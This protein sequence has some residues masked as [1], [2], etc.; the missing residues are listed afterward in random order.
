MFVLKR[1]AL[2]AIIFSLPACGT[3]RQEL[4]F[5]HLNDTY[6]IGPVEE[7][8]AGG[9]GRVSTIIQRLQAEGHDV[10]I[11][12]GGDFLYPS[13]ESQIWDGAQMIDA[14]NYLDRVA[15][16][17]VVAGNHEFD[18]RTPQALIDAVTASTF[19]WIGG[20][21]TFNTGDPSVDQT[22]QQEMVIGLQDGVKLGF[23]GLTL[24]ADDGGNARDYVPIDPDYLA[25]AR[26][27]LARLR[28]QGVDAII[29]V[30]HVHIHT[31][32]AVAALKADYPEL[33]FIVGGHEHEPEHVPGTASTAPVMK[34]ASN[35][36][37]IWVIRL[38]VSDAGPVVVGELVDV[39]ASVPTDPD[40]VKLRDGWRTQ[41]LERFPFLEARIG[42]AAAPLDAREVTVRN[43]ESGWGNFIADQMRV[44][45]GRTPADLAFVNGG[46][47]RLDDYIAGDITFEDVARTFGFSSYLH[48]LDMTGEEFRTVLEAGYRGVGP[49]KGYFPQVSGFRVCVDRRLPEGE[50]IVSLQVPS[51]D[52][53][54]ELQAGKTYRVVASDYLYRGG[55][56]YQYPQDGRASLRGS[57][58]KYLVFDA[59][60]RA[61]AVG[62]AIGAPV[63]PANPRMVF[64][65]DARST[66]WD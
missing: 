20:N 60:V 43:E 29:G 64:L 41:L 8:R 54:T 6:R 47:L 10:R 5:V 53:W 40:Y 66:C 28:A 33:A 63:D 65:N 14:F 57:E 27:S 46:T 48:Y 62:N 18:R 49:S 35:A 3:E 25:S 34:G 11:L 52:G 26:G 37:K 4:V 23:F 31:D 22:L 13:L 55:D 36:R 42:T 44:A 1:I 2:L 9:F 59:I 17:M 50:R 32:K 19:D 39:D 12:H 51:D 61:Q 7:G 16:M 30:T 58:L 24:H 38:S 45:F 21:Y 15:P 56:G